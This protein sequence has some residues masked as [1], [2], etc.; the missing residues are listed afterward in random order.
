MS[1]TENPATA[2]LP[3]IVSAYDFPVIEGTAIAPQSPDAANNKEDARDMREVAR[4]M[5]R[6][7]V[8]QQRV[9]T[10]HTM[11]Q[12]RAQSLSSR[13]GMLTAGIQPIAAKLKAHRVELYRL[14]MVAP[15]AEERRKAHADLAELTALARAA[16][17]KHANAALF[18]FAATYDS[19][20]EIEENPT[21]SLLSA[22]EASKEAS[23]EPP[24]GAAA[25]AP[26]KKRRQV[27][28][29]VRSAPNNAA[30]IK[31]T[32]KPAQPQ[33]SPQTPPQTNDDDDEKSA[34]D[35]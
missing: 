25:D 33:S 2:I 8:Q 27:R 20:D 16:A 21:T 14:S 17:E 15:T 4:E 19:D 30:C 6:M 11:Y 24:Q 10:L 35:S 13:M 7:R 34:G 31:K 18:A 29:A 3:S 23:K 5:L 12:R 28:P 22:T 1:S 26:K 32:T 9:R